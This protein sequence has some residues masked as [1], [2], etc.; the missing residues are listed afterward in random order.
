VLDNRALAWIVCLYGVEENR[1]IKQ[2]GWPA[3]YQKYTH[4]FVG[5]LDHGVSVYFFVFSHT[6]HFLLM[7]LVLIFYCFTAYFGILLYLW[8][9]FAIVFNG[10]VHCYCFHSPFPLNP[11]L[12]ECA[13][14]SKSAPCQPAHQCMLGGSDMLICLVYML[15]LLTG[16]LT[17]AATR[18]PLVDPWHCKTR[19]NRAWGPFGSLLVPVGSLWLPF[20]SFFHPF[21]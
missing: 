8:F 11:G 7:C 5:P 9:L 16:R 1:H 17:M 14:V 3:T 21:G 4:K 13:Q 10:S 2:N 20:C 12:A 15:D 18:I 6:S 19:L